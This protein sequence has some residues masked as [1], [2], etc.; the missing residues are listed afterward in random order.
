MKFT[1]CKPPMADAIG[2]SG[3]RYGGRWDVEH[4]LQFHRDGKSEIETVG[5]E[6]ARGIAACSA[7]RQARRAEVSCNVL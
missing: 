6:E 3:L 4:H 1:I 2:L 7:E 5:G